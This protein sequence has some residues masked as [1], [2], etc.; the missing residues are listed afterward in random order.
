MFSLDFAYFNLINDE[1]K[2]LVFRKP[3]LE[4]LTPIFFKPRLEKLIDM[5]EIRAKGCNIILPLGVNNFTSLGTNLQEKLVSK[6]LNIMYEY[7]I[8]YMAADRNL[9]GILPP[10]TFELPIVFG[11]NFIKALANVIIRDIISQHAIE[12]LIFIGEVEGFE[13]F[14]NVIA[15]YEIPLSIQSYN[16]HL[17]EITSHRMLYEQGC[18]VSNSYINP[19]EWEKGDMVVN[20]NANAGELKL[21]SPSLF[22]FAFGDNQVDLAPSLEEGLRINGI[23]PGMHNLAPIIETWLNIKAGLLGGNAEINKA[24]NYNDDSFLQLQALGEE[25]GIWDLFLDKGV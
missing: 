21:A 11:D 4:L 22:Y 8:N 24:N 25:L 5:R 13:D 2:G 23:N 15:T 20:F 1:K 10:R 16:P 6:S 18:A 12:K 19:S 9:K 17:Y 7:D 14:L 3:F